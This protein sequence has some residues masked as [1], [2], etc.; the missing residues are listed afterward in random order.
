MKFKS[1]AFLVATTV[2]A[3]GTAVA[4]NLMQAWQS[5][6]EHDPEF[7]AALAA[8]AAGDTK[9]DQAKALW[10][11]SVTLVASVGKM[12]NETSTSGAQFAAPGFEQSNG[13]AFDTSIRD[14]SAEH[15]AISAKQPLFNRVLSAQRRQL[16][17]TAD[18][19]ESEWQGSRQQL[20]MRVVEKYFDLMSAI[21]SL[22]LIRQREVAVEKATNESKDR[23]KLGSLPVVDTYEATANLEDIKAQ[24]MAA[25]MEVQIKEAA[26]S[27]LTGIQKIDAGTIEPFPPTFLESLPPLDYW[28]S[29]TSQN[30][31]SLKKQTTFQGFAKEE[32]AKSAIASTPSI[33]LVAQIAR[34]HLS[35]AGD[36]GSADNS[37]SNRSIGIQL[38]LPI[39]TGGYRSSQHEE[40]L[41]L[42]EKSVAEGALLQ[43]RIAL[44]TR[45]AW[46]GVTTGA[47]R[48]MAL[49]QALKA[50]RSRLQAT[51]LGREL[52]DRTTLDL[53]NAEADTT[54]AEY[55]LLQARI[56]VLLNRLRL[57]ELSGSLDES[58]LLTVNS[59]ITQTTSQ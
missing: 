41:H 10:R 30:N 19:A 58:I 42:I 45:T 24:A 47:A 40:A 43:Q 50:S 52:G 15:Y 38:T 2:F 28:I 8:H 27:D 56:S 54:H 3:S 1:F 20:I 33:E 17:L 22:R 12:T 21:E 25:E 14:G 4:A 36:F 51:R 46:L 55:V 53:L 59:L 29:H 7:A 11:P 49:E 35:G 48:T 37:V 6:Q 34:D 44:Q 9:R 32:A 16:V 13:V 31:L 26:F 23:F 57:A 5:A 39:F 18:M